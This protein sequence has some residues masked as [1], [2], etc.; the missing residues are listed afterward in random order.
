MLDEYWARVLELL[1]PEM[2]SI[3]Y[4]TWVKSLVPIGM[5]DNVFTVKATSVF[6]KNII[7]TRY[8]ELIKASIRHVINK[9][10]DLKVIM[11]NE[12]IQHNELKIKKEAPTNSVL[13]PK[14]TFDSYVIGE[15]NKFAHAAALAAAESLGKAYNPL[16]LYSV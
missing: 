11:E 8:G 16:F 6:Q 5:D 2:T 10:L 3:S 15:N 13:N 7:D 12:D 1:Q 9:D 4:D 14:Y